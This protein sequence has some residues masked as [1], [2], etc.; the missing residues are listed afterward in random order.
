MKTDDQHFANTEALNRE[1]SQ[2]T[3]QYLQHQIRLKEHAFS[4]HAGKSTGGP[5]DSAPSV[6]ARVLA[7]CYALS[8]YDDGDTLLGHDYLRYRRDRVRACM[9]T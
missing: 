3:V 7:I 5:L 6:P 2:E 8:G 4:R 1:T 9:Q